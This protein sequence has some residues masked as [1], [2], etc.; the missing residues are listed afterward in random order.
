[1]NAYSSFRFSAAAVILLLLVL[2]VPASAAG[3]W[4]TETISPTNPEPIAADISGSHVVYSVAYGEAINLS[5]PRGLLLYDMDTGKTTSLANAS[6]QMTLTGGEIAGD[7]VV[8]FE[9]QAAFISDPSGPVINN[10][11]LLFSI[12]NGNTTSIRSSPSAEWPKTDGSQVIWSETA[13]DTYITTLSLYDIAAKTTESLPVHPENGASVMFDRDTIAFVDADTFALILY[14]IPTQKK[15]VVS[16]PVRTN[17]TFTNVDAYAMAGD[18]L[19]YKTR[20]V[21]KSPKRS[22]T[23][24]LTWYSI[25]EQTNVTL[26]PT[27]GNTVET[28]TKDDQTA[29]FDSLFTDGNTIGWVYGTGIST[30]DVITVNAETGDVSHLKIDGDVAFPSIDGSR[31]TWVQSK[32]MADSHLVLATWQG[33][34]PPVPETTSAPGFGVICAAGA[35]AVGMLSFGRK[36]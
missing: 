19:L 36:K 18:V 17:T 2:A 32:M 8:W 35:L 29:S 33:S 4:V 16:V 12:K 24:T 3:T 27:T 28:L 25:T 9:E 22:I 6:G 10:S 21:E 31:A 23:N 11:V 14:D 5:T 34:A 20:I 7:A 30:S 26:S 1:M 15:T 13:E